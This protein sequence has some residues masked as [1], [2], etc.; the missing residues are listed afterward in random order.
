MNRVAGPGLHFERNEAVRT[1]SRV[2]VGLNFDC[3]RS[4]LI[5]PDGEY[6][7]VRNQQIDIG[8]FIQ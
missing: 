3:R 4:G 6:A 2:R 8:A 5:C 1:V 7:A